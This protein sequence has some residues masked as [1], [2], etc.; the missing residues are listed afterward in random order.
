[1][2]WLSASGDPV[3]R[4]DGPVTVAQSTD[5]ALVL[6]VKAPPVAIEQGVLI[7]ATNT[8]VRLPSMLVGS[9]LWLSVALP[10]EAAG[11]SLATGDAPYAWSVRDQ[12]GGALLLGA[13][14]DELLGPFRVLE[15]TDLCVAPTYYCGYAGEQRVQR[16]V[17]VAAQRGPV[18]TIE[19]GSSVAL[20]ADGHA[21]Q[22][23][24]GA[25]R[26]ILPSQPCGGAARTA[27][28]H[29]LLSARMKDDAAAP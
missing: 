16:S 9:T 11:S 21:Y 8:Q 6:D 15:A 5:E 7:Q 14:F 25:W 4:Y 19:S 20:T 18:T 26:A 13:A 2:L 1:M 17:A 27:N 22:V 23:Y 10:P 24:V 3:S 12:Q 29:Y 28:P